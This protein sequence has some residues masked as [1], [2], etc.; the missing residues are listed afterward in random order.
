MNREEFLTELKEILENDDISF[1]SDFSEISEWDSLSIIT[2]AAF[3]N[4]HFGIKS[5][6][7]ELSKLKNPEELM[8]FVGI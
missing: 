4:K 3:L 8:K 7:G 6:V 2:L 5:D 1:D